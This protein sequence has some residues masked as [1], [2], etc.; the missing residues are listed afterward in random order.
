MGPQA[1]VEGSCAVARAGVAAALISSTASARNTRLLVGIS[2]PRGSGKS[3]LL[4]EL[5]EHYR[6]TG[7]RVSR[8]PSSIDRHDITEPTAVLVDD[9]H[10]L[11]EATLSR[12]HDLVDD[13]DVDVVVAYR[14]WPRPSALRRLA[15]VLGHGHPPVTLGPL[16]GA[17]IAAHAEV[18]LGG[19]VPSSFVDRVTEL[20][21]GMPWLVHRVMEVTARD[22]LGAPDDPLAST[23]LRDGLGHEIDHLDTGLREF[24]LALNIGFDASGAMPSAVQ[25]IGEDLR[26][27]VGRARAQGLLTPD[28]QLVPLL[29]HVLRE[30]TPAGRTRTLQEEL[31]DTLISQGRLDE[32]DARRLAGEGCR[33]PRVAHVLAQA[34]DSALSGRPARAAQR[35]EEAARAGAD[36]LSTAARRAQAALAT[37]DLNG[38][39]QILDDLL[40]HDHAPDLARGVDV[41]AA[42]WAQRGM[43]ARSAEVYRWQS[44]GRNASSAALAAITLIGVGDKDGAES[45]LASSTHNGSPTQMAMSTA[46]MGEGIRDSITDRPAHALSTLIRASDMMTA[47]GL[48]VPLPEVPA[49]LAA[50]VALHSG[51][52]GLAGSILEDALTGGQGGPAVRPRLLLL[53]AWASMQ[54]E[55]PQ[56]ARAAMAE[57]TSGAAGLAPREELL[58]HAL[59]VGLAR[60]TD[61][62]AGLVRAWQLAR[63]GVLH[64]TVDLYNLLPLG[65]LLVGAARLRDARR[66]EPQLDEAWALLD[67]LGEPPL[68]SVVLRWSAVQA[69]ILSEQ[70]SQLPP[71]AAALVRASRHS[72]L[73]SLLAAAGRS[74]LSVLAGTVDPTTVET[75]ARGLASVG[76]AWDGSRLAGHAAAHAEERKDMTSL[77]ACARD[78]RAN[79]V[80]S[81]G[82]RSEAGPASPSVPIADQTGLSAREREVARFVLEGKT[83]REIGEAMFISP[84]TAEH[85]IARIRRRL[86]V[87]TRQE[88]LARLRLSIDS[89]DSGVAAG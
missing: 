26:D 78:L 11:D 77:L 67:R 27:L 18:V 76:M 17:E 47:S 30:K 35:Y 83:Y 51:E 60:R 29:R 9:A 68:W 46:L 64:G 31:V 5:E 41:A 15:A 38:A 87:R 34:G 36:G 50:L 42:L 84:R 74:W 85:H 49:A 16:G 66:L 21:G 55:R 58:M 63:E 88:L 19:P 4:R 20:T 65:E 62:T 32:D 10:Q 70:P 22:G 6:A 80:E 59:Q 23:A 25:Q 57:A 7:V 37:G 75:A 8:E 3:A 33:D 12:L 56:A 86:G 43:L 61:D 79:P 89:V 72:H 54:Q 82:A 53:H 44:Q 52:P 69:A 24:L 39:G 2:G 45:V 73:A 40:A 1:Y 13:R 14:P 71:H 48:I 28:G 81:G